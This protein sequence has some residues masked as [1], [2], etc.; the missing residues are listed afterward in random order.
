MRYLALLATLAISLG[1]V[2]CKKAATSSSSTAPTVSITIFPTATQTVLPGG[3]INFSATV[4][5]T[6]NTTVNWQV[7]GNTGGDSFIGTITTAG[8]YTAPATSVVINPFDVT[9]T[10]QSA[11]DT[12]KTS[13][14]TVA[15]V[16]P[17]PVS[18]SPPSATVAAGATQ[19]FTATTTPANS[20][21]TW[22]VNGQAG[23]SSVLGTITQAGLYT[24]PQIPPSSG[25]VTIQA[26]LQSDTTKLASAA[27]TLTYSKFSLQHS[28][29]FFLRGSDPSGLLLRAGSFTADGNGAVTGI[30]DITNG[31]NH[32]QTALSFNGTYTIGGDG[33]G[34]VTFND[35]FNGNTAGAGNSKFSVIVV[36]AQQV[37]MEE[38]DTFASAS[39]QADLQNT[40]AFNNASFNGEYTFDL[41]GADSAGRPLSAIGLFLADGVGGGTNRPAQED[42]NDN[43]VLTSSTPNFSFQSVGTNGRGLA[44]LNG[45]SYSFYM[46]SASQAKFISI[47]NP[48]STVGGAATLQ[49]GA[50]FITASLGGNF[51][52]ITNGSNSTGPISTAAS[53]FASSGALSVGVLMQ[54]NAGTVTPSSGLGFTGTYTLAAGGRGTATLSSGQTYVFYLSDVHNGVIQETDHSIVS[55]GSLSALSSGPFT[56]SNLAGGY[57]LQLT[58]VGVNNGEQ[59]ALAQISLLNGQTVTGAADINTASG[60]GGLTAF[61]PASGVAIPGGSNYSISNGTGPFNIMLSGANLTFQ[62]YFLSASSV[63]LLRTDTADARVLHGNLYQDVS[64]SPAFVSANSVSFSVSVAGTFTVA[65]SGNPAPTITQT[66]TLPSGVTFNAQTGVLSGTPAAGTGGTT[67]QNYPI[68]FTATNGVGSPAV[69]NFTLTVVQC[70]NPVNGTC[71]N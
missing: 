59:D 19:Q 56:T 61:T 10:A 52:L 21:V 47:G 30:E 11:A 70:L 43:G 62:A 65:A 28:Y 37:Q 8:V 50:P 5:N 23:G 53:F 40:A 29:E 16:L 48:A 68:T 64:F 55:D 1:A 51:L 27:A 15:V 34:T 54:N 2:A 14:T 24:A 57:A 3:T 42:V 18:I 33:R 69:Q 67:T 63:F 25:T 13:S 7:N 46:V 20:A 36:S 66:G 41:S 44:T 71:S 32:V 49:T 9:V 60:P 39:G 17:P 4:S 22:E 35:G 12:T 58:G 6:S 26:V 45:D 38:L 31:I